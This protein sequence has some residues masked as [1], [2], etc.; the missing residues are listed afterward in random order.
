MGIDQ[1]PTDTDENS[2]KKVKIYYMLSSLAKPGRCELCAKDFIKVQAATEIPVCVP[3]SIVGTEA[4]MATDASPI[5][6]CKAYS[7]SSVV[8]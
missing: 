2:Q 5:K 1:L 6:H 7:G 8:T 3:S 4:A